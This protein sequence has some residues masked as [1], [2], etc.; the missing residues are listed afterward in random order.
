MSTKQKRTVK[1][2]NAKKVQE[3]RPTPEQQV[4]EVGTITTPIPKKKWGGP[5]EGSGRPRKNID[6]EKIR[7][8]AADHCTVDEI[9]A[10]LDC[11]IGLIYDRFY[12]DL[13]IGHE[14]GQLS[15][16]RRMHQKA[17]A[18]D[19]TMLIWLSK[20]RLGYKERQP[21]EVGNVQFNI[22]I[23]DFSKSSDVQEIKADST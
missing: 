21:E 2:N 11:S 23:K 15:L 14:R 8:L 3:K 19:T 4:A 13:R 7:E 1:K 12:K 9:A 16:K 10:E 6:P 17:M 18:G 5:Q 20:Q 22:I